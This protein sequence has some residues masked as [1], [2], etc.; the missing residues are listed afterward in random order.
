M[1][2]PVPREGSGRNMLREKLRGWGEEAVELVN[3]LLTYDP[4]RR[5]SARTAGRH[6]WFEVEPRACRPEMIQTAPDAR[7]G[8][9]G[10]KRMAVGRER[11]EGR[12][13]RVDDG[14]YVFD[15]G[16]DGSERKRRKH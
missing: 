5:P 10:G 1:P 2:P 7:E 3:K 12:G 15:F 6:R 11:D 4:E 9:S 8:G 13:P 14:G 16:D